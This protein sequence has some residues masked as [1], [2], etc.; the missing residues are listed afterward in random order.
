[1]CVG[2]G[3]MARAGEGASERQLE[4]AVSRQHGLD[5]VG[6]DGLHEGEGGG[7]ESWGGV[8]EEWRGGGAHKTDGV[9]QDG[10]S[11]LF[12]LSFSPFLSCIYTYKDHSL[13]IAVRR[14]YSGLTCSSYLFLIPYLHLHLWTA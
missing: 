12:S 14:P 4:T 9:L 5:G 7:L 6:W 1:M 8:L 2:V 10:H 13:R 11:F 3:L